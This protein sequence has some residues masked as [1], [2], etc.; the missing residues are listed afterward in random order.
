MTPDERQRLEYLETMFAMLLASDRYTV[1]KH[2][3]I[4]DGRNI[5]LGRTTGT[6]IGTGTDQKLGFFNKA[7]VTQQ[8]TVLAP[9]GGA[10]IDAEARTA[11]SSIIT[12]LRNLGL[13][14]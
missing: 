1:Q 12:A 11:V 3:Q 4:F 14:A 9:T 6:K 2:I 13:I 10:T 5:Q 8:P 7:P